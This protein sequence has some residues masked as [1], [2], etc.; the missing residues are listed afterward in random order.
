MAV[1]AFVGWRVIG[2]IYAPVPVYCGIWATGLVFYALTAQQF[3]PLYLIDPRVVVFFVTGAILFAAGAWL[4]DLLASPALPSVVV[5]EV[6]RPVLIALIMGVMLAVPAA[7]VHLRSLLP[8]I[9]FSDLL[10]A[11]RYVDTRAAGAGVAP[12]LGPFAN[13][14]PLTIALSLLLYAA[15]L[16]PRE[17]WLRTV[18]LLAAV[19][20]SVLAGG[21]SGAVIVLI[22]VVGVA[23]VRGE[24]R[25]R[26]LLGVGFLFLLI[27]FAVAL[28]V[29]KGGAGTDLSATQNALLLLQG[30][31]DYSVGGLVAFQ[32][33]LL[34]PGEV[35]SVGGA[36]RTAAQLL[37]HLG[38]H[39]TVP[40]VHAAFSM[41]GD[42]VDANV[43]TIYFTY[44]DYGLAG[45]FA[46][47]F[48]LGIVNALVFAR[49]KAGSTLAIAFYGSF[50]AG[51]VTSVFGESFLT[52]V[53]FLLKLLLCGLL[54]L[55]P[56][57]IEKGMPA[58]GDDSAS[59]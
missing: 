10:F 52:N 56:A 15:P 6:R 48:L 1:A 42:G 22:G 34:S 16:Q 43:Y 54:L 37:N 31:R 55:R 17:R 3:A 24:L 14:A 50:F 5:R 46:L 44:L 12:V 18:A 27:F 59:H 39:Y 35:P 11:A 40:E 51:M 49:A 57:I 8:G 25:R 23:A 30:L 32:R 7:Y 47:V 53:N 20:S 38:A 13:I 9:S 19:T 45:S 33:V 29:K 41:I 36:T 4:A 26:T 2:H 21:R 28:L 58:M